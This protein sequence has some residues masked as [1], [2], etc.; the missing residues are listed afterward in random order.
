MDLLW[1]V[2]AF[3]L[4][5]SLILLVTQGKLA[6]WPTAIVGA[7]SVGLAALTTLVIGLDF[8]DAGAVPFD[9]TLWTWM[10]VGQFTP[11]VGLYLDGLSLVMMGVITGVG[12]LI[13]LY[14]TGYM[15]EE[16][17]YARFFSYMNLFV[18]AMLMLVMGDNLLVLF[19]GWEG[20]G[21]CSYLLIGFFHTE[22][23]NGYAV[24]NA[25]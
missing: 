16:D 24:K 2:P 6:K 10:S 22:P 18:F 9:Q 7:G 1:L 5:G 8:Y 21:L 15:W 20:V 14:A 11:A 25:E 12:F 3:P 4:L 17:G 19:L 13:H 23:E